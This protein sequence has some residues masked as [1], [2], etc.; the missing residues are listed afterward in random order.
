VAE[1]DDAVLVSLARDE[2]SNAAREQLY[3][4]HARFALNL[5]TRIAGNDGDAEDV[6]HD[7][8]MRAFSRLDS[9]RKAASFRSWL[10]AIVVHSVR[11]RFRR[12]RVL[13][14]FGLTGSGRDAA[15]DLDA[16]VSSE[17][18]PQARAEVAQVFALL[19]TLAPDD[20]IAWTLRYV[21]GYDLRTA[22]TLCGC[23]LAT[24]K[25][26]IRRAQQYV[27]AHFVDASESSASDSYTRTDTD[28]DAPA[29]S[30]RRVRTDE[31]AS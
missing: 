19:R 21:E 8:F 12:Q 14:F 2:D 6:A 30:R 11:S 20:R 1:L 22:A 5:A 27:E 9:L 16:I 24:V 26:R 18:S 29:A 3:R 17:A 10:G 15:I 7:A 4:R 23:S 31:V 13:R 25:R 28:K